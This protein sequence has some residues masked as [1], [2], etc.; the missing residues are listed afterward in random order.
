MGSTNEAAASSTPLVLVG[1]FA[2]QMRN[3]AMLASHGGA[4]ALD[5]FRLGEKNYLEAALRKVLRDP[6]FLPLL[7]HLSCSY[8]EKAA[9]LTAKLR[10]QPFSSRE[11]LVRHTSFVA[12][13]GPLHRM[14]PIS[15]RLSFLQRHLLD[16]VLL[17]LTVSLLSF[18]AVT[19]FVRALL[20]LSMSH[21]KKE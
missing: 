6:R 11:L 12:A 3:A 16:V 21:F 14:S 17:L 1:L 9:L 20:R 8:A 7:P 13:F 10:S 2:D 4:I 15:T 19:F 5:K 18:L